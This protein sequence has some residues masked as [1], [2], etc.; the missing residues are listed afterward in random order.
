MKKSRSKA[1]TPGLDGYWSRLKDDELLSITF[2]TGDPENLPGLVP[3][4][5]PPDQRPIVEYTYDFRGAK[6]PHIRCVHCKYPNHLAGFV[7]KLTDGR[8]FLVGHD[9]GSKIYGTDFYALKSD[10]DRARDRQSLLQ[11]MENLRAAL[12]EFN[13]DLAGLRNH[14]A[15]THFEQLRGKFKSEMPRLWGELTIACYGMQGNLVIDRHVLDPEAERR[16]VQEY[17]EDIEQWRKLSHAQ[18]KK[19]NRPQPPQKPVYKI[20]SELSGRLPT[21]TFFGTNYFSRSDFNAVINQFE[22]L[23]RTDELDERSLSVYRIRATYDRSERDLRGSLAFTN[24]FMKQT[25]WQANVLL[26]KLEELISRLSEPLRLFNRQTLE[27]ICKWANEHPKLKCEYAVIR[28]AI[29][30]IGQDGRIRTL[31]LSESFSAPSTENIEKFRSA[32]N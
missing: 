32:I 25:L 27:A 10:F 11:R 2:T 28:G 8:R 21:E 3:D 13:R 16:A 20:V 19:Y 7:L 4:V 18:R 17:R 1:S 9:C 22:Q 6:R 23:A 24:A 15:M 26:G 14:P 31:S 12:P 30:E 5:P 29:Q